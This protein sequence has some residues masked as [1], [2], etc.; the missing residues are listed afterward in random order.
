M[1]SSRDCHRVGGVS[2]STPMND[3]QLSLRVPEYLIEMVE[4]AAERHGRP[5]ATE[6][7][8]AIELH[9][10]RA[11][12]LDCRDRAPALLEMVDGDEDAFARF[13]QQVEGDT[14]A[15]EQLAYRKPTT[16]DRRRQSAAMN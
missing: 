5:R 16:V 13:A 2:L 15:L 3:R 14:A 11:L 1:W 7:R 9:V 6:M 4:G 8:I 12:L 10:H